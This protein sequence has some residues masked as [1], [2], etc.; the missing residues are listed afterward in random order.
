MDISKLVSD[1]SKLAG[2]D[3]VKAAAKKI[4]TDKNAR[5]LAKKAV[6]VAKAAGIDMSTIISFA[7]KNTDVINALGK[8]GA[9]SGSDPASDAVQKLVS[10]LKTKVVKASGTKIDDDAFGTI[11]NKLMGNATVKKQV[12]KAAGTGVSSFIKK[13]VAEYIS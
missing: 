4:A 12:E 10:S 9:K 8:L 3:T 1:V 13:A 2:N 11:I 7:A 5:E 6:K